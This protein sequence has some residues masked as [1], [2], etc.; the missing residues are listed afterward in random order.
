[1]LCTINRYFELSLSQEE[2]ES[3]ALELGSDC[4]FF[5]LSQPAYATG[6][7]EILKPVDKVLEGF[8]ILLLNPGIQVNTREAYENWTYSPTGKNLAEII[9]KPVAEWKEL[10]N[11]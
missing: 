11:K 9:S 10:M 6:R 2:L 8:K 5:I 1:M 7:G 3:F 4:P